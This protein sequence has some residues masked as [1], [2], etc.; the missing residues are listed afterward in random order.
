VEVLRVRFLA[1]LHRR[2]GLMCVYCFGLLEVNWRDLRA[3]RLVQ[4]RAM[5][6]VP[7]TKGGLLRFDEIPE[8]PGYCV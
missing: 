4:R 6:S 5:S 2:Y 8:T 7:R 1:R 3:Q